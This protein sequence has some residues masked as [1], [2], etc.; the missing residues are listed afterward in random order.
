MSNWRRNTLKTVPQIA[1]QLLW[2]L[3]LLVG[4]SGFYLLKSCRQSGVFFSHGFM[5][6]PAV[7][8]LASAASMLAVGLLGSWRSFRESSCL[9]GLSVY[10]LVV[11]FCLESTA[12]ALAHF[13][14]TKL[15]SEIAPLSG[16]FQSYTGHSQDPAAR[17][18]DVTQ[19]QL[20]CCG[21]RDYR[22]WL[23][24][25]WFNRSGGLQVP[26]SCCNFMFPSCNGTVEQPEQLYPQGCRVKLER[27][28]QFVLSFIFWS[29][30]LVFLVEIILL[31]AVKQLM[32]DRPRREYRVLD[33]S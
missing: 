4:L 21:V 33:K 29:S 32:K 31:L 12:S 26:Q 11:V 10:L 14:S 7:L 28:F 15:D 25:S 3:G 6:L 23:E 22:D 16:V 20:R 9:Q 30:P 17:A 8:A 1:F 19:E 24:T 27:S 18:V 5:A 2:V 13:Y